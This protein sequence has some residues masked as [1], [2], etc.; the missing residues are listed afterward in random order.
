MPRAAQNN[1]TGG[2]D[3]ANAAG[4][5]ANAPNANDAPDA[6]VNVQPQQSLKLHSATTK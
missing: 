2:G 6:P 3:A 5:C 4:W 1:G